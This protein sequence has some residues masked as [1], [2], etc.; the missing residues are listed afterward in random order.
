M[1]GVLHLSWEFPPVIYGGLG[2][3][4]EH[5][6]RAQHAAG[7]PVTVITAAE[8]VTAPAR[9]IPAGARTWRGIELVRVRRPAP[10]LPWTDVLGAAAQLDNAMADAGLQNAGLHPPDV[11]HAH[12]WIGAQAGRRIADRA[13]ARFVITAHATEWGR[14]QG[15]IGP[16]QED[17]IPRAIHRL[18]R[19][20][21][22]EADAIIVCSEAMRDE[23]CGVL[24]AP[25]SRVTVVPNA[26]DA[27]AWASS[28]GSVRAAREYWLDGAAGPLIAA[29]G[30]LEWEKG[31]STLIR[32]LP[33]VRDAL[34]G[35]RAV[36]AG[37][38]SYAGDLARL[39]RHLQ[40]GDVL[41]MPGWLG[42][43]D[44][45]ALYAAADVVVV[46]SRYE[47][48]GLV[49]RE[50]LAAGATVIA[51]RAGGLPDAVQ[52]QV[53]GRLI[54][55]GDVHALRD[56]LLALIGDPVAACQLATAG[57]MAM[58]GLSWRTVAAQTQRIYRN[59]PETG[60]RGP[61]MIEAG[62][63]PERR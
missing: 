14:R 47:P 57:S 59:D 3:H 43:R 62:L 17:D 53:T 26:V 5:L 32:A 55:V 16:G 19:S 48:S 63:W 34:P 9:R 11:V 39:A 23:V 38:G 31:F 2:R 35:V 18:E 21:M 44:L 15:R 52:D 51:T 49:A 33:A 45:C 8:D 27:A 6:V 36:L 30:R 29:A 13:G 60:A 1:T 4:V 41:V 25:A 12:D 46:P 40:I 56:A 42:R 58:R 10:R 61:A 20:A 37:R 50:A 7:L 54:D 24:D 22:H 28:P